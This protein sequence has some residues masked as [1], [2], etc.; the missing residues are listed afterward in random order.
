MGVAFKL[1]VHWYRLGYDYDLIPHGWHAGLDAQAGGAVIAGI[2]HGE[3][4]GCAQL[5]IPSN[6]MPREV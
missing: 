5:L 1:R 2:A 3:H 4:C 6:D